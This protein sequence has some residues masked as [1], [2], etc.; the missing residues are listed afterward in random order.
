MSGVVHLCG[1]TKSSALV[2]LA[3]LHDCCSHVILLLS[4]IERERE[5]E[6]ERDV[7][8]GLQLI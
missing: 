5:R 4:R 7:S 2:S 6:R 1:S 3:S 8:V